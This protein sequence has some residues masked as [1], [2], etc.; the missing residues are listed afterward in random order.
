MGSIDDNKSGS[1]YIYRSSKV[2]LNMVTKSLAV[3]LQK[4]GITVIAIH[5]GWVETDMGGKGASI[6]PDESI[7]GMR[8]V[9]ED[10]CLADS[11]QFLDFKGQ[12]IE[13]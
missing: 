8:K 5:P 3:D 4:E 2:A 13:W 9:I 11:G 10:V 1:Y 7:Q 6:Q 12:V